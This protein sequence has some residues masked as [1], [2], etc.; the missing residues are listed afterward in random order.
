MKRVVLL[1]VCI[2]L[3]GYALS[4]QGVKKINEIKRS[5]D[6]VY[7]EVTMS[8][9]EEA[10]DAV[11]Q[12]LTVHVMDYAKDQ[13]IPSKDSFTQKYVENTCD[14]I[15]VRRSDMYKVFA[16]IRKSDLQDGP[17]AAAKPA[18]VAEAPAI[19]STP[20]PQ[21]ETAPVTQATVSITAPDAG[22]KLAEAWKQN[23]IDKLL[24]CPS[25]A[26]ARA[27]LARMKQEY[28]V[29][30]YGRPAECRDVKR[31]FWLIGDS[32]GNVVT[33]LGPEDGGRTDFSALKKT[34]L[35]TY[36]GY[37]SIWFTLSK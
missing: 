25:F 19:P 24:S 10:F 29:K 14:T 35:E 7:A 30:R 2:S 34:S 13:K 20:S 36:S 32:D 6:Y 22:L 16:Y 15:Q 17:V 8:T 3:F 28:K 18:R 37:D 9:L 21:Q 26:E 11:C 31:A 33:V 5:G 23:A 27:E 1:I 12:I 4:A